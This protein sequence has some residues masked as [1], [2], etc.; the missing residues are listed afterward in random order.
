MKPTVALRFYKT[1]LAMQKQ[2]K[3]SRQAVGQWF[4]T[5]LI[6]ERSARRLADG[7]GGKLKFNQGL[8]A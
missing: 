3:V 8:Y 6:P 5:G 1:R 7:S 4:E 2:A